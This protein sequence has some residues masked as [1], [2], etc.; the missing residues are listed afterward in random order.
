VSGQLED[1]FKAT[2]QLNES[3]AILRV[4]LREA[5]TRLKHFQ[6]WRDTTLR[7]VD[8]AS[9]RSNLPQAKG[10]VIVSETDWPTLATIR[11]QIEA[12]QQAMETVERT[13]SELD[14]DRQ[15]FVSNP[16]HAYSVAN[17][18]SVKS[19]SSR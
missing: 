18:E 15:K 19:A 5:E 9:S 16:D 13:Y 1:Y 17:A 12:C 4:T 3:V 11:R 10:D 2:E 6:E 8:G 14:V 7:F